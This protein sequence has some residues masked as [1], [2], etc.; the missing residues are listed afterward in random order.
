MSVAAPPPPAGVAARVRRVLRDLGP[1]APLFLLATAGP[2]AGVVALAATAATWLPWFGPD[3]GSVV[4]YWLGGACAAALCLLPTHATSLV[5]GYLFGASLGAAVAWLVV[6]LAASLSFALWQRWVG[7]RAV[8]ALAGSPR[9]LAVHRA[10]LGRG[11]G[12]TVWVIALLRLSPVMPF[13]ATN[14]LLAAFGVRVLPFALATVLGTTPRAIGAAVVGAGLAELDWA[15]G[16][17]GWSQWLAIGATVLAVWVV[18]R[19][20]RRALRREAELAPGSTP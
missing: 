14:L 7:A 8:R 16:A 17:S 15:A 20:A 12:R 5:A 1:T 13:A 19:I 10:L 2:A 3:P 11:L 9:A 6:V 4:A 18:G